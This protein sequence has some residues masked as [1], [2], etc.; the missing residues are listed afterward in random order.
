M[1]TAVPCAADGI[2]ALVGTFSSDEGFNREVALSVNTGLYGI[3][4]VFQACYTFTDRCFF[5]FSHKGGEDVVLSMR[6][7]RE[8]GDVD[9]LIG[10]FVNELI[11]QRVRIDLFRRTHLLREMIVAQAFTEAD[12]LKPGM[13]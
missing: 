7:K 1:S 8:D 5:H 4:A 12:L 13:G 11:N 9:D 6:R 2:S 3:D 10:E